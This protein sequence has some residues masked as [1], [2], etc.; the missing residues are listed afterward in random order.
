MCTVAGKKDFTTVDSFEDSF[1][2]DLLEKVAKGGGGRAGLRD[3]TSRKNL[4]NTESL[5]Y[6][7]HLY[8]IILQLIILVESRGHLNERGRAGPRERKA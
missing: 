1:R 8:A 3:F 6:R 4:V 2:K 5:R 7:R